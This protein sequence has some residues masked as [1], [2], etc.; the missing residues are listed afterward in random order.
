MSHNSEFE[1]YEVIWMHPVLC[2]LPYERA[3]GP[4]SRGITLYGMA[5]RSNKVVQARQFNNDCIPVIFV[6]GAFLEIVLDESLREG[7]WSLFLRE[8]WVRSEGSTG[9]GTALETY[10]MFLKGRYSWVRAIQRK[11][12]QR[13]YFEYLHKARNVEFGV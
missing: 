4:A 5:T 3:L 9:V 7:S 13:A 6:K 8:T 1:W 11:H 2:C 10:I 12:R